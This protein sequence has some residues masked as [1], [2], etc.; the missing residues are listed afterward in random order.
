MIRL[1]L[2]AGLDSVL[3]SLDQEVRK[4]KI[5]AN[6]AGA[7]ALFLFFFRFVS[8]WPDDFL[9]LASLVFFFS[10]CDSAPFC[11]CERQANSPLR[12]VR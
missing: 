11:E 2:A 12:Q 1:V 10:H 8:G 9:P 7:I 5:P 6:P 4:V 3:G